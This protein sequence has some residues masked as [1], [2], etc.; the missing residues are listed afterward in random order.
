MAGEGYRD[1]FA[2]ACEETGSPPGSAAAAIG[3]EG[4]MRPPSR[5]EPRV[6]KRCTGS[7]ASRLPESDHLA[8]SAA[9]GMAHHTSAVPGSFTGRG[10]I[11][12][13]YAI[14]LAHRRSGEIL[15]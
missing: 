15:L 6:T 10:D 5:L 7:E 2:P 4:R 12:L 11:A 1:L 14:A 3:I 13:G 9:T 8:R